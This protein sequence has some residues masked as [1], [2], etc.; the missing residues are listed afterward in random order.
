M[1]K[2]F[3]MD[4]ISKKISVFVT[5]ILFVSL[6][7]ITLLNYI[8]SKNELNR[9]NKIILSNAVNTVMAEIE[10][11]NQSMND[12]ANPLTEEW[13]KES[14]L[15]FIK[16]LHGLSQD[17]V[18][19][20]TEAESVDA[21]SG[22]TAESE[23]GA[24]A[25][26]RNS[27]NY[28]IDLG[29]SGYFYIINSKGDILFH[30]FLTENLYDLKSYDGRHIIQEIIQLAKD[31]G[32]YV[33]YALKE[34]VSLITDTKTVYTTYF[35][36]WDWIVS[37]VIYD[38]ELARG[39]NIIL[40]Y[41]LQGLSVC[42]VIALTL[43]F[44][45]SKK[46]T[47]PIKEISNTL[48]QVAEGDL[49]IPLVEVN[50]QDETKLLAD[51]ANR[52]LQNLHKI[53]RLMQSS[54]TG[55]DDFASQLN[56]S[57]GIV[58][59]TAT[60]VTRAILEMAY[61]TEEQFVQSTESVKKVQHLGDDI[62]ATAE[63]S[64]KIEAVVKQSVHLKDEGLSSVDNLKKANH[65]NNHNIKE[66]ETLIKNIDVH[67]QDIGDIT[68][69]IANVAKQTNLLALNASIEASRAGEHGLGFAVVAEEIRKLA[70]ESALSSESI[71]QKIGDMQTQTYKAVN[72]MNKNKASMERIN[73]TVL[74]TE[75]VIDRIASGLQVLV[76]DINIIVGNNIRINIMKDDI[77]TLLNQVNDKAESNSATIEE[78]SASSEEQSVTILEVTN[79]ITRLYDMVKELNELVNAFQIDQI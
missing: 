22:A 75:D 24:T 9:S 15:G 7:G 13:A 67:S 20:A 1:K 76:E 71:T 57:T 55:L 48:H 65:E 39:S 35:E 40:A 47:K 4:R 62:K 41:N 23:S 6:I 73:Q 51:S 19:G 78:I 36:E 43:T 8:I 28:T 64:T 16:G 68:A 72:F 38:T 37:A 56:K 26:D 14:T 31:G 46:I 53:V 3:K 69:I 59:E 5:I 30:P 44:I 29:K 74:Q 50:T 79:S 32:G 70:N 49:T 27:F 42:L 12:E 58:S 18:T 77:V 34:D 25:Y 21:S 2:L 61:S 33:N 45:L 60:E 66:I 11:D 63:A 54:S 10:R 17:A 52:L